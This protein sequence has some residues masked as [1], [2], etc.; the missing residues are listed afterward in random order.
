MNT[1]ALK[2]KNNNKCLTKGNNRL[3]NSKSINFP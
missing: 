2:K 3:A 1:K